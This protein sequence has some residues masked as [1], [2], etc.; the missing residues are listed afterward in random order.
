MFT[1][2]QGLRDSHIS[3]AGKARPSAFLPRGAKRSGGGGE[4]AVE[5]RLNMR[6]RCVNVVARKGAVMKVRPFMVGSAIRT[7][8]SAGI[9]ESKT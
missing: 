6:T 2:T 5:E 7:Y 1:S 8:Q 9:P 3:S 4:R